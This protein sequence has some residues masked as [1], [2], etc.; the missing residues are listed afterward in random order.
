MEKFF[1]SRPIFAIS[2]AIVIVLVASAAAVDSLISSGSTA[3]LRALHLFGLPFQLVYRI[4]GDRWT[5]AGRS[6]DISTSLLVAANVGWT[7]F[8]SFI[9][10]WRYR[11][12]TVTK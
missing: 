12:L 9:V 10:W 3:N 5:E 8:F 6:D 7:M 4:Y 1:V 2:L 11:I